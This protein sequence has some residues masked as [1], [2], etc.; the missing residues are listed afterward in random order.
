MKLLSMYELGFVRIPQLIGCSIL[1]ILALLS[2]AFADE[3]TLID[4]S[5]VGVRHASMAQEVKFIYG[6]WNGGDT[7]TVATFGRMKITPKKISWKTSGASEC[8]TDYFVLSD[9]QGGIFLDQVGN[10]Y[11]ATSE[12]G[13]RYK[14]YFVKIK[15]KKCTGYLTHFRF[16]L[17]SHI[18]GYLAYIAY[19]GIT[20]IQASRGHFFID[21]S[22]DK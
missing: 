9:T 10:R 15:H 18:Q 17:D 4:N 21:S 11:M 14:T 2:T 22:L 6:V 13:N 5:S 20:N 16:T 3:T 7:G 12:P 1:I 19:E 8:A